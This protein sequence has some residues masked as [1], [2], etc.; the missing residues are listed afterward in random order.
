LYVKGLLNEP[1]LVRVLVLTV[2]AVLLLTFRIKLMQG[3][4]LPVFTKFDN[5]A[6]VAAP[7]SRTLSYLVLPA[8]NIGLLL[9]PANLCCDWTMGSISLITSISDLRNLLTLFLGAYLV[10]TALIIFKSGTYINLNN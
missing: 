8:Y 6:S 5:P 7:V 2:T 3:S 1:G 4:S 10:H 9:C